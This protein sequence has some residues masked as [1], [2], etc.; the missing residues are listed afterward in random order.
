VDPEFQ[1]VDK[2]RI[3]R[4]LSTLLGSP[5]FS[6]APRLREFLRFVVT[7]TLAGRGN[8]LKEYSIGV[9]VYGRKPGFDPKQ[10]SIVRVE[11]VK[12]RARLTDYYN[13][14]NSTDGIQILLPK[15]GYVPSIRQISAQYDFRTVSHLLD[16]LCAAGDF[17]F[18]RRTS[19]GVAMARQHFSRVVEL[20]PSD[21]RGHIGLAHTFASAIDTELESPAGIIP[22]YKK[23]VAESLRLS[24]SS[25]QA[26]ALHSNFICVIG[27]I[28]C[29]AMA[30]ANE[31]F[32]LAPGDSFAHFWRGGLLSAQGHFTEALRHMHEA[33]RL[34]PLCGLHHAYLGRALFY[35]G[36]LDQ[37]A[38]KLRQV[39]RLDPALLVGRLWLALALVESGR[40]EEAITTASEL[41]DLAKNSV[42]HACMSYV[43]ARA[44]YREDAARL[45][46]MLLPPCANGY[47][48]PV[49]LACIYTALD[50]QCEAANQ[51]ELA[52]TENSCGFTWYKVDARLKSAPKP[53]SVSQDDLKARLSI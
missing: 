25:S 2:V 17:A 5:Y 20:A 31:A 46:R 29:R 32:R 24:P 22:S 6:V 53:I 13:Q 38:E 18:W 3:L 35:A 43:L 50:L 26:H 52:K 39:T 7:E 8:Q 48:A 34:E 40:F 14:S 16:E 10:D 9:D 27:D 37:S 30:E 41:V 45:L 42:T 21:P 28:G 4:H 12:L 49:W 19:S 33:I 11:A 47:V 15:G 36:E 1:F 23:E 51:L 44:G